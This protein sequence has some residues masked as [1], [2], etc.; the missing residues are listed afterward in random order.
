MI[1]FFSFLCLFVP[2]F[3]FFIIIY[4]SFVLNGVYAHDVM[5]TILAFQNNET[6]AMLLYQTNPVEFNSLFM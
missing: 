4:Y 2:L 6:T 1:F 5:P 3:V